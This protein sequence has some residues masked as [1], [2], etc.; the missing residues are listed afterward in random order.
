MYEYEYVP[1]SE[2]G[3]TVGRVGEKVG[4]NDIILPGTVIKVTV[5]GKENYI[6]KIEG[7]Y[8]V[9]AKN[10]GSA[11]VSI[12]PQ[13]YQGTGVELTKDDITITYQNEEVKKEEYEIIG[14]SNNKK[15]GAATVII[16]GKGAF[17][18]TKKVKFRITANEM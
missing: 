6:G 17:G 16:Q 3:E 2:T 11:K 7:F 8:R 15:K 14:Y 9:A 18:G 1:T 5:T 13:V 10:I 4:E 12:E